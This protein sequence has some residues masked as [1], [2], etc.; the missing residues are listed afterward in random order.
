MI[1]CA[2]CGDEILPGTLHSTNVSV[3]EDGVRCGLC[4]VGNALDV[5]PSQKQADEALD[6]AVRYGGIDGDHHKRWVIDQMIRA[7]TGCPLV[8]TTGVDVNGKT[9]SFDVR[10]ESPAYLALVRDACAGEDGPDTYSWDVG[11]AP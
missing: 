6:V 10:G 9:Y 1:T 3:E 11:V 4:N 2:Y 7:L 8:A 5:P